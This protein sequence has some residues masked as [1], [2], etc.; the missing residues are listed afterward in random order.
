MKSS[1]HGDKMQV[2][3][4]NLKPERLTK[5]RRKKRCFSKDVRQILPGSK[6]YKSR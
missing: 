4:N 5:K 3:R 6:M 1:V 2:F